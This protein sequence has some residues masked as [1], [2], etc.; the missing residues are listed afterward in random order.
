MGERTVVRGRALAGARVSRRGFVALIPIAVAAVAGTRSAAAADSYI[1]TDVLNLRDDAGVWGGIIT[2]M[3]Q[4]ESISVIDGPTGDGWYYINYQGVDGWAWGGYLVVWGSRGW[5]GPLPSTGGDVAAYEPEKV[6]DVNR[7]S[8]VVTLLEDGSAVASYYAS[9]GYDTSDQGFYATATGTYYIYGKNQSLT[10]TEWGQAYIEDWM[11]F[12]SERSNG[13]HSWSMDQYGNVLPNG[14][15]ATG[16]C[17]ALEPAA[18]AA[19]YNWAPVGTRVE[20]HW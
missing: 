10:W 9:Y 5:D 12:D 6:I 7:S 3:Y 18:A 4:G 11:A 8:G 15:G 19:L 16:G 17:I 1:D 2:E 13:F 20:I 14:D